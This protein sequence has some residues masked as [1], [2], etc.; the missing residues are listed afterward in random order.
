MYAHSL[1]V[2]CLNSMGDRNR[3]AHSLAIW[4]Y[5]NKDGISSKKQSPSGS[6]PETFTRFPPRHNPDAQRRQWFTDK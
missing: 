1:R 6:P 4:A 3:G 2:D 5:F